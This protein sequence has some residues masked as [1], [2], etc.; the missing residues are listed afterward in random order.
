LTTLLVVWGFALALYWS[1]VIHFDRI[2]ESSGILYILACVALFSFGFA[3]S[4]I[5][6][7]RGTLPVLSPELATKEW[8]GEVRRLSPLISACALA[9][10]VA[11][12]LF[13]AEMMF[14][15]GVNPLDISG[16]RLLYIEREVTS[17]SRI[18]YV[19]GAGGF[20]SLTAAILCW[21]DLSWS[22]RVL[23]IVSPVVLS[24]FSILSAGRQTILQLILLLAFSLVIR[25][26]RAAGTSRPAKSTSR[27]W[28]IGMSVLLV[29][30]LSYAMKT[31]RERNG[32]EDDINEKDLIL[33]I[34]DAR[35]AP[36]V[37]AVLESLPPVARDGVTEVMVYFSHE[38][39]SFLVFWECEFP[40]PY[41]GLWEFPFVA[42]RLEDASLVTSTVEERMSIAYES[43]AKSG[44]FAQVWQTWIRDLVIDFGSL[45][46][47][48]VVAFLGLA[49]GRVYHRCQREISLAT[50]FLYVG[51]QLCCVYAVLIVPTSDTLAFFYMAGAVLFYMHGCRAER[52]RSL[53]MTRPAVPARGTTLA[54]AA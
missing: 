49:A 40:G 46:A 50:S 15:V 54:G 4:K 51:V 31:G 19:I 32:A 25:R 9:G 47:L 38:I 39:P 44:R 22:R 7:L 20:F 18:A 11:A 27:A 43:F 14:F 23:W 34:F 5:G 35:I 29:A 17:L 13:A 16:R 48:V 24:A 6:R 12:V 36:G 3:I 26:S 42:R 52:A 1:D 37:D 8:A 21:E 10:I 41:L 30:A 53:E 28:L 2:P 33:S 45:G